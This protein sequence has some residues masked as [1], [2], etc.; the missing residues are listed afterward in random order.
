MVR[1]I[2]N[3]TRNVEIKDGKYYL[4]IEIGQSSL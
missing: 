1:G 4:T 3:E 2:L